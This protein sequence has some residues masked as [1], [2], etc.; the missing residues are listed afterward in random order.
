MVVGV[1]STLSPLK[2]YA[3]F[4]N[5]YRHNINEKNVENGVEHKLECRHP[6]LM[7]YSIYSYFRSINLPLCTTNQLH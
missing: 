5:K 2:L 1:A 6:T 3:Q 7:M 4:P